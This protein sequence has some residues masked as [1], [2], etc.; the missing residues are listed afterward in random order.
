M[1]LKINRLPRP[2]HFLT[3]YQVWLRLVKEW[4]LYSG[5]KVVMTDGLTDWRTDGRTDGR[6]SQKHNTLHNF[7]VWGIIRNRIKPKRIYSLRLYSNIIF[8]IDNNKDTK[9]NTQKPVT[10]TKLWV[11]PIPYRKQL[12]NYFLFDRKQQTV[13]EQVVRQNN[14][15]MS[16][17]RCKNQW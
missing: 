7:V 8:A 3:A 6:T 9:H 16:D 17:V 14:T 4:R 15:A 11:N 5:N 13:G 1:T 2:P 10:S 12:W